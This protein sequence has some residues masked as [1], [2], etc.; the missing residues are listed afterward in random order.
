[1]HCIENI[2]QPQRT[3]IMAPG[4]IDDAQ[5]SIAGVEKPPPK[6]IFPDGLRTSGQHP[7][8]YGELRPY[9]DFP[10]Y[11]VSDT[12]WDAEDYRNNLET[13]IHRLKE[14]EIAELGE[15][16]DRFTEAGIPLTGISRVCQLMAS[17][18]DKGLQRSRKIS[19]YLT[20]QSFYNRYEKNS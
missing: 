2:L 11:I 20:C 14:E 15:A 7:P 18:A 13:W 8:L 1:M 10:E 9:E 5:H 16:A 3:G 6:S 17:T 12:V 19:G 4:L